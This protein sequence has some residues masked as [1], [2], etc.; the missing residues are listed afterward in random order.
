MNRFDRLQAILTTLQSKK[1]VTAE[2]LAKKFEVS[3]RTIYR[4]VRSLEE[5]GI[6]IGAEAGLGYYIM[7]GF[8]LP[9]VMFTQ[10]EA[11]ALLLAGKMVEKMSDQNTSKI[12]A[13]ALTK[14]SSVLDASRKEE[15]EDLSSKI[16]V[17]PDKSDE[18]ISEQVLN[19]IKEALVKTVQ[20]AFDYQSNSSL[21]VVSR[22]ADPLGLVYYQHHWHLIAFCHLRNDYRDFRTDRISNFKIGEKRFRTGMYLTLNDYVQKLISQTDL[23]KA[24]IKVDIRI[25]KYMTNTKYNMGFISEVIE[26]NF[27]TMEFAS[28]SLEYFS[29]WLLM[30][31]SMVDII[32]PEIL[33]VNMKENVEVLCKKY[34]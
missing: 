7:D 15:M 28:C 13:A 19:L 20:I 8:Y 5:S 2:T 30:M 29:K 18:N 21:E 32:E 3:L 24:I 9:P 11:R 12:Y 27:V 23:V 22:S 31:G 1:I 4:D 16:I 6:P 25:A 10:E 26:E 14:I 33:K 34:L 17:L